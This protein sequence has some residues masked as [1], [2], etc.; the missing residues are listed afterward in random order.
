MFFIGALGGRVLFVLPGNELS[1]LF[2][3]G[4][5]RRFGYHVEARCSAAWAFCFG[6]GYYLQWLS[7]WIGV[8]LVV[9]LYITVSRRSYPGPRR[10][11]TG[12][13]EVRVCGLGLESGS[14]PRR[15]EC[16]T[17]SL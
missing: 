8:L 3:V 5:R 12:R 2:P 16:R 11:V 14:L 10:E 6:M 9:A 13:E 17:A 4:R 1:F 15:G 7:G